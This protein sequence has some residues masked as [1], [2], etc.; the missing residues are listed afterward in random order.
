MNNISIIKTGINVS[1]I[2]KQIELHQEDWAWNTNTKLDKSDSLLN[3]GFPPMDVGVLQLVVGGVKTAE[4]FVG[5]SEINIATEN[6]FKQTEMVAW[7]KRNKFGKHSRCGFLMLPVGGMVGTHID[8]GTYYHTR[9]RYHLS[10]Y[11]QY[12]YTVGDESVIVEPGT[13][14]WFNNKLPHSAENTGT[15]NRITFVFDV[16]MSKWNPK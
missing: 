13:L 14:L 4:E 12:R 10:I 6:Y 11:G 16:P 2:L 15:T 1:K 9:D 3:Y 8:E 7:L 5:N